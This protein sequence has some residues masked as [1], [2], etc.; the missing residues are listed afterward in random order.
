ML[1]ALGSL[2]A[3]SGWQLGLVGTVVK[4]W[5]LECSQDRVTGNYCYW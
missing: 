1:L 2:E 5:L 4:S 3:E